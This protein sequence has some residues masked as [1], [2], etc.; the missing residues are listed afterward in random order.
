MP[1]DVTKKQRLHEAM[2]ALFDLKD[3]MPQGVYL[4]ICD[5]MKKAAAP[6]PQP[7]PSEMRIALEQ[8][9]RR[10]RQESAAGVRVSFAPTNAERG[11]TTH[12][13][14]RSRSSGTSRSLQRE[15]HLEA[16]QAMRDASVMAARQMRAAKRAREEAGAATEA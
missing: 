9:A 8:L 3:E 16:E 2:D 12:V 13:V 10:M 15:Q 4:T 11:E 6:P 1:G 7:S 14:S 5:A